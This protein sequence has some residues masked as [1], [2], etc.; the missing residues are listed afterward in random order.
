MTI[1]SKVLNMPSINDH[2]ECEHQVRLV[3]PIT[4][5]Q[6]RAFIARMDSVIDMERLQDTTPFTEAGADSLDFFNIITEIQAATGVYIADHDIEQVNT[7]AG[8]V[9]YLNQRM[10]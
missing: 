2:P 10:I 6:M 1:M 3:P 8:L 4:P 5:A 7:L 9:T